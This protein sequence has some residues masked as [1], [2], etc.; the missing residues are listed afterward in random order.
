MFGDNLSLFNKTIVNLETH[1]FNRVLSCN[2]HLY[3]DY[4]YKQ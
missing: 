2:S 3:K 4:N 1:S